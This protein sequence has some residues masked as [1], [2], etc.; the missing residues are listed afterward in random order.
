MQ[1]ATG[2][3]PDFYVTFNTSTKKG[4][5]MLRRQPTA[6]IGYII[7]GDKPG[8]LYNRL[9]QWHQYKA[10]AEGY[11]WSD[12]EVAAIRQASDAAKTKWEIQPQTAYPAIYDD[13]SGAT[14]VTGKGVPIG[15]LTV[16]PLQG[17]TVPVT[18]GA[19]FNLE[20]VSGRLGVNHIASV[21][22]SL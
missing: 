19:L 20:Q 21:M 16:H 2:L 14:V 11:V 10:V 6:V 7:E 4:D 13:R 17:V 3:D 9:G 8:Y 5:V 22:V 15:S 1:S 12:E 18:N